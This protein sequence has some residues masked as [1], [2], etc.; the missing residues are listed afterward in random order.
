MTAVLPLQHWRGFAPPN[1]PTRALPW[2]RHGYPLA[3]LRNVN[4]ARIGR[5][6]FA[7]LNLAPGNSGIPGPS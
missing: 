2:T 4:G 5:K 7:N 3:L 1:H 6:A